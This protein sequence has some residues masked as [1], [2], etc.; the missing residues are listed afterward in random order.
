VNDLLEQAIAAHGGFD[1][2]NNFTEVTAYLKEEQL[3]NGLNRRLA[4]C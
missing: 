4:H 1:R 2:W 3:W